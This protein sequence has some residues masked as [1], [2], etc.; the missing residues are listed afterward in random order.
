MKI[1][2]IKLRAELM[3]LLTALIWG[4]TFVAQKSAMDS[5]GPHMFN[6]ARCLIGALSLFIISFFVKEKTEKKRKRK[7]LVEGGLL[8]GSFLFLGATLQQMGIVT[9][10]AGHAGFVSSLYIIIVPLLYML[11][12]KK[13]AKYVWLGVLLAIFGL[14]FL[15]VSDGFAI[16]KGDLLIL[17]SAVFFALHIVCIAKYAKKTDAIKLS[18]LQFL[19]AGIFATTLGLIFEDFTLSGLSSCKLELFCAG[20]LS[21]AIGFTLQIGAQKHI[22]PY[23]ASLILSLESVFAA[24]SGYF[25]L[26]EI[27]T[28]KELFGCVLMFI[29]VFIA[30]SNK[31]KAPQK[32]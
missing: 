30:Q 24:V 8:A 21:C 26:N 4:V 18:C 7:P 9:S 17:Y 1:K 19:F 22:K 29:A 15:C 27:L 23:I 5:L 6:G 32:F 31:N 28:P 13:V 25:I 12:G 20:V 10:S 3:L 11:T 14:Y 16:G 2:L